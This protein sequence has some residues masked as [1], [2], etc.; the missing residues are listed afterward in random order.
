MLVGL[1]GMVGCG[2]WEEPIAVG[3]HATLMQNITYLLV[4]A[5]G[6]VKVGVVIVVVTAHAWCCSI[7]FV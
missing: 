3:N 1:A 5:T 2:K 7:V 6:K 4:D